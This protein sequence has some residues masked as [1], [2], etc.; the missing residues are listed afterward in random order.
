MLPFRTSKRAQV[1]P[2]SAGNTSQAPLLTYMAFKS[3]LQA[4]AIKLVAGALIGEKGH[5]ASDSLGTLH[6]SDFVPFEHNHIGFFTIYDGDMEKYFQ[7]FADKTS[8]VF[9]C[10]LSTCRGRAANS[11][12]KE[13]RGVLSVGTRQQLP[14]D[15]VLQ[16]LSRPLGSGQSGPCWPIT[17][18]QWPPLDR[19]GHR[20]SANQ[21]QPRVRRSRRRSA[22]D[23][24]R[25]MKA[26]GPLRRLVGRG[27][28]H[29]RRHRWGF[30][31]HGKDRRSSSERFR[32]SCS[33]LTGCRWCVTSC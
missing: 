31:G 30:A 22:Y 6:F 27:R 9:D 29:L 28:H 4:F 15:R 25:P 7:D 11:G 18:P 26:P 20:M 12:G 14:A 33:A 3:R 10:A 1:L 21:S 2:D 24:R 19:P 32:G 8:F 23:G 13:R 17:S 16:R 5:E